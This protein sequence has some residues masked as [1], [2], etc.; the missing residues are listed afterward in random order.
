M[1]LKAIPLL[2]AGV[3]SFVTPE[4]RAQA[5]NDSSDRFLNAYQMYTKAESLEQ[6]RDYTGA[7]KLLKDALVII[8]DIAAKDKSWNPTILEYRRK[9]IVEGIGR[10][11]GK[12]ASSGPAENTPPLPRG[13]D[14]LPSGGI[15]GGDVLDTPIIP[16]VPPTTP[17]PGSRTTKPATSG[18]PFEQ[19]R[20]ERDE[21]KAKLAQSQGEASAARKAAEDAQAR[22]D[23]AAKETKAVN[24]QVRVLKQRA[25]IAEETLL[26]VRNKDKANAEKVLAQ[27]AELAQVKKKLSRATEERDALEEVRGQETARQKAIL[28]RANDATKAAAEFQKRLA[29]IEKTH[30]AELDTVKAQLT[31]TEAQRDDLQAKLTKTEGERDNYKS[32]LAKAAQDKKNL[33]KALADNAVLMQKL[34]DAEKQIVQFKADNVQKDVLIADL[35]KEIA[36]VSKQLEETKKTSAEYQVKMTQLQASLQTTSE[37]LA[38]ADTAATKG[39][40]D[41]KKMSDENELLRGIVVRQMKAQAGR[42]QTRKLILEQMKK[43]EIK[44]QDLLSRINYL[45]EPVVKLTPKEAALFKKPTVEVGDSEIALA[46]GKETEPLAPELPKADEPA[47]VAVPVAPPVPVAVATSTPAPLTPA[48]AATPKPATPAPIAKATPVATP[49]PV[50]VAAT[51]KPVATPAPVAIA[52]ATPKPAATPSKS[53]TPELAMLDTSRLNKPSGGLE[54][55]T[56]TATATPSKEPRTEPATGGNVIETG[57]GASTVPPE[58]QG[59][60]QAAKDHFDRGNYRDAE[61]LYETILA[62]APTNLYALSNLGVVRFREGKL[63]L[64]EEAFR[65]AIAIAPEDAFSRCTLGII[66]YSQTR[67]DEAVNELTKSLAINPKYAAA[68]NFLG[69]TASQKGWQE[70]AQKELET[71]T[72]LDPNYADAHFNLAVVY[73]TQQP[74]TAEVKENARKFYKR[75]TELGA[76]KDPSLEA[77][78]K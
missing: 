4:L 62:K 26:N 39:A 6:S 77:L 27:E 28:G 15:P 45:G 53:D 51:P 21:L 72:S 25:D 65:K 23:K 47:P 71:A 63:K 74:A 18:D 35:K 56:N 14:P 12:G 19:A 3:L 36:S 33:E 31:K 37:K 57:A 10:L 43:M 50:A 44:S 13:S 1:R 38:L 49:A 70:A 69:I 42:D 24:D 5:V 16:N 11:E 20:I 52:V 40:A 41:K 64:A 32:E 54:L 22:L 59:T 61:K 66:Y 29:E 46:V 9:R 55:P 7:L 67:Y 17:R 58:L 30:K 75:A 76:E 34:S 68:H 2:I 48:V 60:A 8:D 73:A 78:L